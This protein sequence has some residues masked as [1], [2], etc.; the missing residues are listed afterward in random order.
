MPD[1]LYKKVGKKYIPFGPADYT[2][3]QEYYW[4][5]GL[6]L[7]VNEQYS[8]GRSLLTQL[9][10]I[11]NKPEHYAGLMMLKDALATQIYKWNHPAKIGD[12]D[13][14][15]RSSAET[16]D[17]ILNWLAE[18]QGVKMISIPRDTDCDRKITM[19]L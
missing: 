10:E 19:E 18:K 3:M 11:P 2:E 6:W 4:S 16:A 13:M 15:Y 5:P 1:Q 8:R 17:K 12:F 9:C 14:N 7:V